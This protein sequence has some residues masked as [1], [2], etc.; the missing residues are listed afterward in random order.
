M[1]MPHDPN[2]S[3]LNRDMHKYYSA[4]PSY[5]AMVLA[6]FYYGWQTYLSIWGVL[7]PCYINSSELL[8]AYSAQ[9][10]PW[11]GSRRNMNLEPLCPW[12]TLNYHVYPAWPIYLMW[13][14]SA[15]RIGALLLS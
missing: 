2:E 3:I 13:K 7:C 10:L 5:D 11:V 8:R 15:S 4:K 9:K 14:C 6:S 1:D 12:S